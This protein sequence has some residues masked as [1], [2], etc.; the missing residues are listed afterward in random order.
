[1]NWLIFIV[2]IGPDG[3]HVGYEGLPVAITDSQDACEMIGG[4]VAYELTDVSIVN[5]MGVMF[6]YRCVYDGASA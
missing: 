5:D 2:V 4:A 1:M 6:D 3:T